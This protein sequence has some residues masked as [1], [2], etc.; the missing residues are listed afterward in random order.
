MALSMLAGATSNFISAFSSSAAQRE[1][2]NAVMQMKP[3]VAADNRNRLRW[4]IVKGCRS[5]F[6]ILG[7]PVV[8]GATE[9]ALKPAPVRQLPARRARPGWPRLERSPVSSFPDHS[10]AA[11]QERPGR[12]KKSLRARPVD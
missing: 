1:P 2:G 5:N 3:N 10:L 6:M 8:F 9:V 7:F 11:S 4:E 12:R